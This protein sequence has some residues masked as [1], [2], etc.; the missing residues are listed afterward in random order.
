MHEQLTQKYPDMPLPV[1]WVNCQRPKPGTFRRCE[2][3]LSLALVCSRI[4][5]DD[6]TMWPWDLSCYVDS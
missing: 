2:W 3:G 1:L 4:V 5:L 6:D